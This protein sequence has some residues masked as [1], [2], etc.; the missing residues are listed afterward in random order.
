MYVPS[1]K[2]IYEIE[3]RIDENKCVKVDAFYQICSERNG[4]QIKII[5][6]RGATPEGT[7]SNKWI[8]NITEEGIW[9]EKKMTFWQM[10]ILLLVAASV[11]LANA[12]VIAQIFAWI[13]GWFRGTCVFDMSVIIAEVLLEVFSIGCIIWYRY[14]YYKQP[15]K[16]LYKYLEQYIL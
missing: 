9:L 3:K 6:T 16:I 15:E 7:I 10:M 4:S 11:L 8:G 12:I 2:P 14:M 1:S 5:I 13:T